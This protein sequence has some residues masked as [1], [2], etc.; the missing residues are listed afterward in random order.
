MASSSWWGQRSVWKSVDIANVETLTIEFEAKASTTN[1]DFRVG[2]IDVEPNSSKPVD[3]DLYRGHPTEWTKVK[4]EIQFQEDGSAVSTAY[5]KSAADPEAEYM[6]VGDYTGV[7]V[8][9][10]YAADGKTN[11]YFFAQ[12]SKCEI[13]IDNVCIYDTHVV[14]P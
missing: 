8:S 9:S 2:M 5:T 4:I 6:A 13:A 7:A 10:S 11:I 3:K 14:Q 12:G 1:P